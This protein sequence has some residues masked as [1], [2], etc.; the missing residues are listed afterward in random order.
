MARS[1]FSAGWTA[2]CEK[3]TSHVGSPLQSSFRAPQD[4]LNT[5]FKLE[6]TPHAPGNKPTCWR[7]PPRCS[8]AA[9]EAWHYATVT[10]R[11]TRD[12]YLQMTVQHA[13]RVC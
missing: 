12:G 10:F 4:G 5:T 9:Q 3:N 11:L 8:A 1:F 13:M 6:D 2:A 7:E